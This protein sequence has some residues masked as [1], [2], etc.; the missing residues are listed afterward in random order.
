MK[1]VIVNDNSCEVAIIFS[2]I[3]SHDRFTT[4]NPISAGYVQLT[5]N[6]NTNKIEANA[7]GNSVS[8]NLHSRPEDAEII[9]H[10]IQFES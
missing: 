10:S 6:E 9:E 3:T 1:Y 2:E 8:L 7:Y 5:V 4:L